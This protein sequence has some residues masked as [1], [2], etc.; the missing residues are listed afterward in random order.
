MLD[1][2][3]LEQVSGATPG[4]PKLAPGEDAAQ[5]FGSNGQPY[6]F[7]AAD[8]QQGAPLPRS[9]RII[10]RLALGVD[11]PAPGEALAALPDHVHLG[12]GHDRWRHIKVE[13]PALACRRSPRDRIETAARL[14]AADRGNSG[15]SRRSGERET[16]GIHRHL[17]VVG[18]GAAVS[19]APHTHAAHPV[20]LGLPNGDLHGFS[21][22]NV[23]Q[24]VV[25][26]VQT[27]RTGIHHQ[28]AVRLRL[29][30]SRP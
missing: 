16:P 8:G 21:G 11:G 9:D 19:V 30:A 6:A 22:S 14:D 2:N 25:A 12:A 24:A 29:R 23:A 20:L 17:R 5:D 7:I 27:D 18:D 3:S 15:A 13:R 26:V 10:R 28:P 1:V 4:L